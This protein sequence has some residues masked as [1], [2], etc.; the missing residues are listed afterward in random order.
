MFATSPSVDDVIIML[1][2]A[3]VYWSTFTRSVVVIGLMKWQIK[4]KAIIVYVK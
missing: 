4:P 2:K 1:A 3:S